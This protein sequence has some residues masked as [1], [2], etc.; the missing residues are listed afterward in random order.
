[1]D[2]ALQKAEADTGKSKDEL[3]FSVVEHKKGF[4]KNMEYS[5]EVTGFKELGKL[6]IVKG[7]LNYISGDILPK[8]EPG[9]NVNI[10][11]NNNMVLAPV[12]IDAE[13]LVQISVNNT[14][15]DRK[16]K[17]TISDDLLE[18]YI[19]VTYIPVRIYTVKDSAAVN[20]LRVE[21]ELITESFPLKYTKQELLDLLKENGVKWGFILDNI[22]KAVNGGH[23]L[24]AAGTKC[25]AAEDEYIKYYFNTSPVKK[26][27]ESEGR[28]DY[29]NIGEIEFVNE[30]SLLAA[31]YSG[32]DGKPGCDIHGNIIL[33]EKKKL[34]K[35]LKGPGTRLSDDKT[36]LI[37][38][39]NGMPSVK[40]GAICIYSAYIVNEDL[41]LKTGNVDF[42]GDVIIK[43]SVQEGMKI[44]SG[45]NVNIYGDAV[46]SEISSGG[47]IKIARNVIACNIKA[48]EKQLNEI[49]AVKYLK[50][51]GDFLIKLCQWYNNTVHS[52]GVH[53]KDNPGIVYKMILESRFGGF[54][55]I[56]E[57]ANT[58][59]S[60]N[61]VKEDIHKLWDTLINVF[62]IIE[63]GK[64]SNSDI[65]LNTLKVINEFVESYNILL[66]PADIIVQYCQ[67]ST[68]N[69]T[70]SV[71]IKGKGCY[72]T[73][74]TAENTVRLS[75]APGVFRGGK[76]FAGKGIYVGE[77]GSTA[78]VATVL[79]TTKEGTIEAQVAYP[80]TIIGIEEQLYKIEYPVRKLKA[81]LNKGELI[82]EKLKL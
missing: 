33:P 70:N 55:D 36:S 54:K 51:F 15:Q 20:F 50:I 42:D 59:F 53:A 63:S 7:Q 37:S 56:I 14:T 11:V 3:I 67:N 23:F 57:N 77:A 34:I 66:A 61:I 73:I 47:S 48:G 65:L 29:Y 72:N 35:L 16:V 58:F 75:G 60:R 45:N 13:A 19:D 43:G 69:A 79:K 68:L 31:K 1:M 12:E 38:T 8:I 27:L 5:I 71:E 10:M 44:K 32:S 4:L 52:V 81:Y 25:V 62:K 30:G 9:N 18:A 28:V 40:N 74:I 80:N 39:M 41:S 64:M 49:E 6:E 17:V 76:I 24:V 78:G 2:E 21:A 46:N 82:V 26:P 22:E